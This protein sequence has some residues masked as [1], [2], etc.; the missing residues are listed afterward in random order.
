MPNINLRQLTAAG[1]SVV[2]QA[3]GALEN[4]AGAAGKG[5]FSI[6]A[7]PN[8][9]PTI[10][11]NFNEI[12]KNKVQGSKTTSPVKELWQENGGKVYRPIVFPQD[13]DNEHYMIYNVVERTRNTRKEI[14]TQRVIRTIVLPI[15]T[16]L[17][18]SYGASY[19]NESLGVF[20][21]MA[22]GRINAADLKGAASDIS[23]M[24]GQKIQAASDA[25][26]T[27]DVDAAVRAAGT[28][29]PLAAGAAATGAAG[30]IG[31][32]LA[33]GGTVGNVAQGIGVSEGLAI[34]PHMAV[35]FQGVDFR[36]HS[37]TY[38][39]IAR[40]STESRLIK[41]LINT[42]K[43]HMHPN[44]KIGNLAFEYPDEFTIEFSS[45]LAPYLYKIGTCVLK[46][47]SINYNAEGVPAFFDTGAPVS[48]EI[49]MTFQET[50]IIT[51]DNLDDPLND[52]SSAV[53]YD[54]F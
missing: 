37:F 27:K 18:T 50:K 17:A 13:L 52:T 26:K 48:V 8:G 32:L 20:G 1:K 24:I 39:F 9:L 23:S 43:Y 4:I 29:A 5:A 19:Q 42:L 16:N 6:G 47:V 36:E 12:I 11:A 53:P 45:T 51:K 22:A 31:G 38:K 30:A 2:G 14:G 35:L 46:N 54:P 40:N 15:P 33:F 44:Y 25:I 41:D 3:T 21:A 28:G 7:G 10:S 34:N 49:S